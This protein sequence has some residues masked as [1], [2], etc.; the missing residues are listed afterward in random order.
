MTIGAQCHVEPIF[1]PMDNCFIKVGGTGALTIAHKADGFDSDFCS[2]IEKTQYDIPRHPFFIISL[3]LT[4]T[5]HTLVGTGS[6]QGAVNGN[7]R[8]PFSVKPCL[9]TVLV[10]RQFMAI[11][12]NFF[13]RSFFT[14]LMSFLFQ[15]MIFS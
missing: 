6:G 8:Y 7:G 4:I 9:N 5:I 10:P 15:L 2:I 12:N 14:P 11:K 13:H 3:E 1:L